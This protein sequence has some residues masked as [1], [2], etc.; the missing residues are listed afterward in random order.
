MSSYSFLEIPNFLLI[1]L[2]V[3]IKI[4]FFLRRNVLIK[5]K[6]NRS[7]SVNASPECYLVL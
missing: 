1:S 4:H 3:E 6:P 7:S 2:K 5:R